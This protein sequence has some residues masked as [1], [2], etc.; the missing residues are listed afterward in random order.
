[1]FTLFED[2]VLI[3]A[4]KLDHLF[5]ESSHLATWERG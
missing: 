2:L 5:E 4:H 3:V 1:M